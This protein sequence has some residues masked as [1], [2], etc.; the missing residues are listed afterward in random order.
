MPSR[1][2]NEIFDSVD[3]G[4]GGVFDAVRTGNETTARIYRFAI[5]EMQRTQRERTELA[6]RWVE[7]PMDVAGMSRAVVETWQLRGR[8]RAGLMRTAFGAMIDAGREARTTA[9]TVASAGGSA[10]SAGF[11]AGWETAEDAGDD[12]RRGA[13]RMFDRVGEAAHNGRTEVRKVAQRA[14]AV[15]DDVLTDMDST[16]R[17]RNGSLA[18][19]PAPSRTRKS[20]ASN[21]ALKSTVARPRKAA[22]QSSGRRASSR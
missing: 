19:A 14:T 20:T 2:V 11:N 18:K 21:R 9:A 16:R 15:A 4:F 13:E 17:R 5:D 10:A 8:R 12:L 7:A 3:E 6:R 22:G 1:N